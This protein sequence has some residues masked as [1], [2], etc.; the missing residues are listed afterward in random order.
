M[1]TWTQG[2]GNSSRYAGSRGPLDGRTPTTRPPFSAAPRE[3]AAIA[4]PP[5]PV[6]NVQPDCATPLPTASASAPSALTSPAP[7]TATI[8]RRLHRD[9]PSSAFSI[10]CPI[11]H[12]IGH[13]PSPIMDLAVHPQDHLRCPSAGRRTSE[14]W[15]Q[16]RRWAPR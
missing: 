13:V 3:A 9:S 8:G 12:F 4:P 14:T 2:L 1:G 5:P 6:S 7:T 11:I 16:T 10:Y 15:R